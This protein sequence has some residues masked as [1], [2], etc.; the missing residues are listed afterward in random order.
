MPQVK[1]EWCETV[2]TCHFL[3]EEFVSFCEKNEFLFNPIFQFISEKIC[4]QFS[5]IPGYLDLSNISHLIL[6]KIS[7]FRPPITKH[8]VKSVH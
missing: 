5:S 6:F 8:S 1:I 7:I 4:C 3:K 2:S